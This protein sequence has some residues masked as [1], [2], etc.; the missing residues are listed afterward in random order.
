MP[1][2]DIIDKTEIMIRKKSKDCLLPSDE[3]EIASVGA[4][5]SGA[6]AMVRT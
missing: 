4:S 2:D 3:E 5:A 1:V 6:D